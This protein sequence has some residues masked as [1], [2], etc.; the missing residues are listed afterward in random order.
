MSQSV[1]IDVDALR[2][3]MFIQLELGWMK[4]P[5][6]MSNFRLSSA[7]QIRVLREI[8]LKAVRYVPAKSS[9][10]L[11]GRRESAL[12]A[13]A[14]QRHEDEVLEP[15]EVAATDLLAQFNASQK[16]CTQRFQEATRT[17][18][19]VSATVQAEPRQAREQAETLIGTSVADLLTK[20]PCAVHL[21][22]GGVG[23]PSAVHAVNVM[24][25]ALLLGQSLGLQAQ[26]LHGLGV[27]A[28]LHDIGKL[29]LPA[30]VGEPGAALTA[31]DRRRYQSHVGLS[32]ELAQRMDLPSDVLI[33]IAQHHEMANGSGYP[34]HLLADDISPWGQIL[35]LVNRY[36]RLCNPLHGEEALTPHEAVARLFALLRANFDASVLGAFI[37]MMGV[38]PPGSLVQLVDGRYAVVVVV[39]PSHALRPCVVPYQKGVPR[40]DAA[41]LNLAGMPELGILRSLKPAQLPRAALDYLLSQPR[42][43]YFFERA[44]GSPDRGDC[45]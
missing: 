8:G 28:L 7:E 3:G 38:Y 21:L 22:A 13:V 9:H 6:P 2:V 20:G 35:A 43:S 4:H 31:V 39:D 36:D 19:A 42:I 37:R 33:A 45:A 32:V 27:S 40:G 18:A 14:S 17:Y 12:E 26:Q 44:L 5:F 16:R 30:Y 1:L 11:E 10:V 15:D 41:V 24:V 25:L 29:G 23:Q 34:L